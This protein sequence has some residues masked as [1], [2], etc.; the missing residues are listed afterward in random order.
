MISK[1]LLAADQMVATDAMS[2]GDASPLYITVFYAAA[3]PVIL[4]T[5]ILV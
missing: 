2:R 5:D 1:G 3:R 4:D